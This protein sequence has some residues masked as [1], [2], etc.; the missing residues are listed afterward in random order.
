MNRPTDIPEDVWD[1]AG[2][3]ID[4]WAIEFSLAVVISG[5]IG[6]VLH[7]RI[8]R[9]LVAYGQSRADEARESAAQ[10][11][12]DVAQMASDK[13]ANANEPTLTVAFQ[14]VA[15]IIGAIATAIRSQ[16]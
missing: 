4:D 3:L 13:A 9:A 1:D 14:Q 8:A 5:N 11:C 15:I 10:V 16:K 7:Q 2:D 6:H 12:K